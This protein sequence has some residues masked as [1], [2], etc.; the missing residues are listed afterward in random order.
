MRPSLRTCLVLLLATAAVLAGCT[1]PTTNTTP[2][3]TAPT[4]ASIPPQ[5]ARVT[6][7]TEELFL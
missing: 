3:T 6:L 7:L 1:A 2:T 5:A 4:T